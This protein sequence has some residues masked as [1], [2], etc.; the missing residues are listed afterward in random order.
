MTCYR[1]RSYDVSPPGGYPYIQPE[2]KG[3]KFHA[4]PMIEAQAR[5][6]LAYRKGNGLERATLKECIVDIDRYTC[7]RLG[8]NP[9]FCIAC[10]QDAPDAITLAN[11][12]P[13]LNGPCAGCGAAV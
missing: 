7:S 10:N 11:N 4:E 1:L 9:S 5:I 8:N 2:P 13:G 6:V 3:Q 12:T